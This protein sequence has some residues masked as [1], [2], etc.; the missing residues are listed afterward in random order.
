MSLVDGLRS[1][2]TPTEQACRQR[3]GPV[4]THCVL[5]QTLRVPK[6]SRDQ[7]QGGD[8]ADNACDST[9]PTTGAKM[10]RNQWIG[11]GAI[12][13]TIIAALITSAAMLL[14]EPD[15]GGTRN[16]CSNSSTCAGRDVN[17]NGR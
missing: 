15:K 4:G 16:D 12:A 6:L 17:G 9:R 13:A 10:S 14:A 2:H 1:P 8:V 7:M 3:W 5:Y 11:I